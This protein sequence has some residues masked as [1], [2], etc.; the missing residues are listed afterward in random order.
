MCTCTTSVDPYEG[1]GVQISQ[2][3]KTQ[4]Q[5]LAEAKVK[6]GQLNLDARSL[7]FTA[8]GGKYFH[9]STS[10]TVH[11]AKRKPSQGLGH[12]SSWC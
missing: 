11:M 12:F 6:T 7:G 10:R 9:T 3:Q 5:A 1:P 8:R 4:H 2:E